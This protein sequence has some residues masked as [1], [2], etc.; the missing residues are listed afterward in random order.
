M[1]P[2]VINNFNRI[3]T[4]KKLVEDLQRLN[5]NEIHILDNGSTNP[6]VLQLYDTLHSVE[7]HKHRNM[8]PR[9]IYDTGLIK[10]FKGWVAYTD[11]D[12]ELNP[13]TPA[14]FIEILIEKA[15]KWGY[16]KAGLA[17]RLDDI[18]PHQF[19]YNWKAWEAKYWTQE[20]EK[21]VYHA[22][23]DTTFCVIRT[24]QPFSYSSIRIAGDFTCRHIPWYSQ[25]DSLSVE[26]I[27]YLENSSNDSTYK[28]CYLEY[29][30]RKNDSN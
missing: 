12:I 22:D 11:S 16:N 26:E 25:W 9:A 23:V 6:D 29:K 5:Y 24:D 8:G 18:Q 3:S 14:G 15:E 19:G 2:V 13:N 1:T 17:L 28:K 4:V 20:L 21:D 10:K 7:V 30:A 27:F